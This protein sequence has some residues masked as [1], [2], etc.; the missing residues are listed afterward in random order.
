MSQTVPEAKQISDHSQFKIHKMKRPKGYSHDSEA[1]VAYPDWLSKLNP[2]KRLSDLSLPGT[3][4]TMAFHGGDSAQTQSMPLPNQLQSGIRVIDVRCRHI[5]NVF[6]IHHG[7][8]FQNAFFGDVLNTVTEFLKKNG[9]E[10]V[11]MR[12]KEE[13]DPEKNTRSFEETFKIKYWEPN[14][15][16]FWNPQG[17]ANRENPALNETKGKIVVLQNFSATQSYGIPWSSFSIQDEYK[18][19]TNWDLYAKWKKVKAHLAAADAH[20][21]NGNGDTKYINFLSGAQGSFPYFIASGQSS[22]QTDAPRLMT[23]RTT[24]GWKDWPDFP[25]VNCVGSICSIAFEG[26]NNLAAERI[27][28]DE[29]FKNRSGILMMDFPGPDLIQRIIGLNKQ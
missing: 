19:E 27:G 3:H 5:E 9:S 25:R 11:Y 16:R 17:S 13:Y 10:T 21:N 23:G 20:S 1:K 24:P 7:M 8:V 4:D 12:V 18:V 29:G 26:T 22:P 15:D 2:Q 6:A 28:A 14:R